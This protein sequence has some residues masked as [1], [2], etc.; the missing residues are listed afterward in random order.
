[1]FSFFGF[2]GKNLDKSV[3]ANRIPIAYGQSF[4][5]FTES[6]PSGLNHQNLFEDKNI[7][8]IFQGNLFDVKKHNIATK[9]I[10]DLY[11]KHNN[12]HF[13]SK[14]NGSFN[15]LIIDKIKGTAFIITDKYGSRPFFIYKKNQNII[16]GSEIKHILSFL[17][18]KPKINWEGWGQYLTFRFTLGTN[19]FYKDIS[20]IP[21]GTII[22]IDF[23]QNIEITER[24]Y[25]DY[26]EIEID[27][28]KTFN[29]KISEG[30]EVF[31]E[32]FRRLGL[33]LSETKSII[34]LSG[35]YDSRTIVSGLVNFSNYKNFDT[36]T[37]LHPA[38]SEFDIVKKLAKTLN[39]KYTFIN[40]PQNIYKRFFVIKAYLTDSLVQ[41]HLWLM[42]MLE[43]V[44]N[45]D[46]YLDGMGGD[47]I[48][49]STRVRP[50]HIKKS[51]DVH[52]LACLFK[53]QFGF[54]YE[55]LK[56][57]IDN[58]IWDEIKYSESWAENELKKIVPTEN[59]MLIFLMKNRLRNG[60]SL[61]PNN[62][63]GKNINSVIFP[64][65]E[66]KIVNFG[67]SVPH[68]FKFNYIYRKIIDKAFPEINSIESTSDEN[69]EKLKRYD[70]KIL[71]FNKNPRELIADY[72][73]ISNSDFQY[74]KSLLKKIKYPK[75]IN[76]K[77]VIKEL[78]KESDLNRIIS[79]LDI[80]IWYNLFEINLENRY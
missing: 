63:V 44:S 75:F 27:T 14:L 69:L 51:G 1:M 62:I 58:D 47:L 13:V 6:K 80:L 26:D 57:F 45:Y 54:E 49:R 41:E 37:T 70:Q 52:F 19:T 68:N 18:K 22:K 21:N 12:T 72:L 7:I 11:V 15:L 64:F 48:M 28:N 56:R 60:I 35:G 2:L 31:K 20:L 4:K 46:N 55:W 9:Y 3:K 53:K 61:S 40:R 59:R 39:I 24:Q 32:S 34:A 10:L 38:G 29:E 50:I 73:K 71:D 67:F 42:P 30:V 65:L 5:I 79:I 66:D 23:N 33:I 36:I 76:K 78:S 16:F 8:V 74:L 25:W 43:Y 17:S 77:L